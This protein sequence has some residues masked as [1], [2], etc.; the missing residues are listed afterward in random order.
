[1]R[2]AYKLKYFCPRFVLVVM[3]RWP[4]VCFVKKTRDF[5]VNADAMTWFILVYSPFEFLGGLVDLLYQ[6]LCNSA[7]ANICIIIFFLQLCYVTSLTLIR[8]FRDGGSTSVKNCL[9]DQFPGKSEL[10]S[11]LFG[12]LELMSMSTTCN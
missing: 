11:N 9:L 3:R 10:S 2:V 6:K 4:Y 8:R 1:M 7:T 5:T 12:F